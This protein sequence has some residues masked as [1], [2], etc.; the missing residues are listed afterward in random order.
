MSDI[1]IS[2]SQLA[3]ID[4]NLV[5]F[6]RQ[7][8]GNTLDRLEG[9][10][11]GRKALPFAEFHSAFA[12]VWLHS[13]HDVQR[14]LP[15][16]S[17]HCST[18]L[19]ATLLAFMVW[20]QLPKASSLSAQNVESGMLDAASSLVYHATA[21]FASNAGYKAQDVAKST[22][23]RKRLPVRDIDYLTCCRVTRE[24]PSQRAFY[25]LWNCVI[26]NSTELR[27]LYTTL[28]IQA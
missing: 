23:K 20:E 15:N 2:F 8:V 7:V 26:V 5:I 1:S 27:G 17:M 22:F 9:N 6:F 11:N 18:E 21:L 10:R 13:I 16:L 25:T 12:P 28:C 14:Y 3:A 19:K 4:G 24:Y